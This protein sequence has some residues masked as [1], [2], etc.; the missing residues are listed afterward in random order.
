M[1][2]QSSVWLLAFMWNCAQWGCAA[3]GLNKSA[4]DVAT[5]KCYSEQAWSSQGLLNFSGAFR[6]C[7][8][9]LVCIQG[10]PRCEEYCLADEECE[11]FPLRLCD[12]EAWACRHKRLFERA[13]GADVGAALAFFVISGLALSAGIGGGGLYVPLLM[14]IT[15]FTVRSATAVSQAC[16]AGGASTARAGLQPPAAAPLRQET[17]DRL[18]PC[19][20][21]GAEPAHWK[22][23]RQRPQ[24][25]SAPMADPAVAQAIL[26][27]SAYK[28]FA[29]AI[30]T[31]RKESR[32]SPTATTGHA[33]LSKNPVERG[34]RLLM[35][36][37]Y[38]QFDE[39]DAGAA[40]AGADG[41]HPQ[42]LPPQ[43][44]GAGQV[45]QEAIEVQVDNTTGPT[46]GSRQPADAAAQP[47]VEATA[48][49]DCA[50]PQSSPLD[51]RQQVQFPKRRLAIFGLMWAVV[52]ATI[53]ARG[54]H[55][56]P[57]LVP[58]CS[59]WYWLLA[60]LAA[61]VLESI[62]FFA[63]RRAISHSSPPGEEG[64]LEWTAQAARRIMLWSLLAG[65]MA[66]LCG[67]GGGMVMG[68]ILLNLGFLP[69]VQSA[70]T[71]TTLFVMST[72][73]CIAYLVAGTAP[74]DYSLWLACST[75]LGAVF[76]KAV[77]GWAVKRFQR[78]S[79]IMFLLGGIIGASVVV[80]VITGL[81]DVVD[82]IEQGEDMGFTGLCDKKASDVPRMRAARC[83][84]GLGV[85]KPAMRV[86]LPQRLLL[87]SCDAANMGSTNLG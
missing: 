49:Q 82:S 83:T 14:T 69:Q 37:R 41:G 56:T 1:E 18:R 23:H 48:G 5:Q 54:G 71:A 19:A 77:V 21:D 3:G 87:H 34:L 60:V 42:N 65:T 28:T 16:L 79:I 31:W 74:L 13:A 9:D 4:P 51:A 59:V 78:P 76:G 6:R 29:K 26:C 62:G 2:G 66:A 50:S 73:T 43:L 40:K 52:V 38:S 46:D 20:G 35:P 22:P 44:V 27:Q 72:S 81:I 80:M 55:A 58:F 11:R 32:A 70:T 47:P 7:G 86:L 39:G 45:D 36:R 12:A 61:V 57:G 8:P 33:R 68:P 15:G 30:Q 53:F 64:G 25:L 17:N 24:C 10:H 84:A 63:A 75:G 67:I 85:D